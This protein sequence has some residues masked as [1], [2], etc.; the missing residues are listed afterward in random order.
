M[1]AD[2]KSWMIAWAL[3]SCGGLPGRIESRVFMPA[4]RLLRVRLT[5]SEMKIISLGGKFNLLRRCAGNFQLRFLADVCVEVVVDE[6]SSG[7]RLR[8]ARREVV[9]RVRCRM[10]RC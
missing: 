4:S 1:I 8:C 2:E 9:E 7:R 10:K 5:T 3:V 6:A